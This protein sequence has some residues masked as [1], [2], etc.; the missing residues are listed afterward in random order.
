M[1]LDLRMQWVFR[2]FV[3]HLVLFLLQALFIFSVVIL[4]QRFG[5]IATKMAAVKF[6]F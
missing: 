5:E 6:Y 3:W 1:D 2:N 4:L